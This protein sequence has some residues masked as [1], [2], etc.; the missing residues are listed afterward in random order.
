MKFSLL[1]FALA[2]ILKVASLTNKKFRKFISKSSVRVLIKT[3]DGRRGR[4]FVFDRGRVSSVAGDRKPYD[5]ALVWRDAKTGFA[6]MTDKGKDASFNAAAAGSLKI[7][8]MS[9]YAQWFEDAM[10]FVI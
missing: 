6:V 8:G 2:N 5:V 10:A 7:L 3:A 4:L 9:V 1:L